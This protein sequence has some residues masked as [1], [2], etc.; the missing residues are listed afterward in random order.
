MTLVVCLDSSSRIRDDQ[1]P[2]D[3]TEDDD[4]EEVSKHLKR[5]KLFPRAADMKF[6]GTSAD[7]YHVNF[8]KK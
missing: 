8:K 1:T 6:F 5:L 2:P 3:G 4:D 7:L